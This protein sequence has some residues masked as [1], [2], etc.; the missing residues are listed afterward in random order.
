MTYVYQ[1]ASTGPLRVEAASR[2][3]A[4]WALHRL[5]VYGGIPGALPTLAV[6]REESD[7]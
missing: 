1:T 2:T 5:M 4:L 6:V 7:G 3:A